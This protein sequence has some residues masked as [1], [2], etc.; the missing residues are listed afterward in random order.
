MAEVTNLSGNGPW[1]VY[2]HLPVTQ[3]FWPSIIQ[4]SSPVQ[5]QH[6]PFNST[7]IPSDVSVPCS[8]ET[9]SYHKQ[10]NLVNDNRTQNP[11]YMVPC[12]WLFPLPEFRNGQRPPSIGLIDKRDELSLGK[13]CSSSSSFNTVAN[14][15]HQAALPVKPKTEA[16]GWTEARSINEPGHPTRRFPLDV[17]EQ[18]T[19]CYIIGNLHGPSLDCNGHA[20]AVKQEQELQL[21]SAPNT[22][23]SS[24]ASHITT[25]SLEKK[26]AKFLCPGKNLVDAV[27]AAEARKR[28]KELT[29]LKGTHNRQ[30][31]MQC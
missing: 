31:R 15:D 30:S 2:N 3:L 12:P 24:T 5:V 7:A 16:S 9:D 21:H 18:K 22:K 17:A 27:A 8:S 25:S 29:K 1:F 6:P 11:L 20:S 13:Q 19:G 14:V 4:S 28:R 23:V 26:Q 10:N